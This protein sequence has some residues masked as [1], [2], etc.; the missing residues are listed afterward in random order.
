MPREPSKALI[1][2]LP[3]TSLT[4]LDWEQVADI[5]DFETDNL[6]RRAITEGELLNL[7]SEREQIDNLIER[8]FGSHID[9]ESI[10]QNKVTDSDLTS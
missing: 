7:R 9:R 10:L 3:L 2:F 8:M 4:E 5:A 6:W 1:T